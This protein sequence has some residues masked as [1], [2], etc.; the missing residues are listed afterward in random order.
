MGRPNS[1]SSSDCS[2]LWL[3]LD[4]P[5]LV[6][7]NNLDKKGISVSKVVAM[8]VCTAHESVR[9]QFGG[10]RHPGNQCVAFP[11]LQIFTTEATDQRSAMD[12]LRLQVPIS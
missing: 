7:Q 8:S 1:Q 10:I 5:C 6:Q 3:E 4:M 9:K 11:C 12:T 2:A